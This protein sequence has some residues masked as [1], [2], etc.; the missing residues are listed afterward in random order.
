MILVTINQSGPTASMISI[1]RDLFVYI[2]GG[3]MNRINTAVTQGGIDLLRRTILYNLGIPVHYYAR[4]DFQGFMDVVDAMGGLEI[5]VG[6]KFHDWRLISPELD[7]QLEESWAQFTLEPGVYHM[8]GDLALW[9]ARSRLS[10]NDFYRGRRQQQLLRAILNQGIDLDMLGQVPTLW[11]AFKDNIETDIDLGRMLQLA[12]MAPAIRETGVSNHYLTL[13]V[14]PW[15]VPD[16]GAYVQLPVWQGEGR[17]EEAFR[18][19]LLPPTLSRASH[20]PIYV[21]II[22]ATGNPDMAVLAADN[23]AWYGFVPVITPDEVNAQLS[24]NTQTRLR[25]FGPNFKGSYD[26]LFSWIFSKGKSQIELVSDQP[27]YPYQYQAI[28]GQDYVPCLDQFYAPQPYLEE[29]ETP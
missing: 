1:P 23:L 7:P 13:A 5:P 8:D 4:I 12:A 11:E 26:W 17:M 22:N 2:P 29:N 27:D 16:T 25:Y 19:F 20:P 15:T 18:R 9:Y 24:D 3:T 6:C 21:E 14:D 28:L 10:T